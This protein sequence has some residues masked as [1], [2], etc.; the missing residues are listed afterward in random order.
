MKKFAFFTA[1]WSVDYI[2]SLIKGMQKACKEEHADIYVFSSYRFIEPDGTPNT[3]SFAIYDLVNFKDFDGIIYTP[4]LLNDDEKAHLLYQRILRSKIPAISIS[5][6]LDGFNFI[7]SDNHNY[8]KEL[9]DHL[10]VKHN[11]RKFIFIGGPSGNPGA[12][13]NLQAYK[14]VLQEHN[15]PVIDSNIY[16]NGDWTTEFA[17]NHTK[18][19]FSDEDTDNWP[20]AIVCV[21]DWGAI[22]ASR[23][24]TEKGLQVPQDV[25]VIGFDDIDFAKVVVP[26][27]STVST[28]AQK[29]G[30]EAVKLLIEN[31]ETPETKIVPSKIHYR[32]SCG[33]DIRITTEQALYS[34]ATPHLLDESQRFTSQLRHLEDVFIEHETIEALSMNLQSYFEKRHTFEGKNFAILLKEEVIKNINTNKTYDRSSAIF[35]ENE[36]IIAHIENGKIAQ[37]GTIKT[38]DLVPPSMIDENGGSLFIFLAIYN[39]KYLHGYYVA[40]NTTSMLENKNGYN[41]TRN[42]GAII[43]KFRQTLIYR[44][45]SEQLR[46]LSTKDAL[47]GLFNR[48]GLDTFAVELFQ[49]NNEEHTPTE[50]IFIDIN[51]M[52]TINDKYG[53]LHGDLAVKTVAESIRNAIP[54]NYIAVRYGG[55]EFIA[56]GPVNTELNV[57][58]NIKKELKDK[59]TTMSL[60]YKLTVSLGAKVFRPNEKTYL[61]DA[62]KEVDE[63]MYENKTAFHQQEDKSQN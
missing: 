35:G 22:G 38:R 18:K 36:R 52:K 4:N 39:Q 13:S 7:S 58:E 32:Q 61:L 21:N 45:M 56:M 17:Y 5:T 8:Y 14:E 26:S 41:W 19:I 12:E 63:I 60:P 54:N 25:S 51:N 42:F 57:S 11:R 23:A 15:I 50:I 59:T 40:K 1:G 2:L 62:I 48:A 33:C 9:I 6:P 29:M 31:P 10:I 46:V 28:N 53:H 16:L 27:I 47:S 30:Y 20:D 43:E 44:T 34:Q 55:D 37:R 49:M 3:T 24:I